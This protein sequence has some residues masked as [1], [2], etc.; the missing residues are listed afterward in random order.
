M[1]NGKA[2]TDARGA[3]LFACPDSLDGAFNIALMDAMGRMFVSRDPVG[4]RPM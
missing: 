3:F 4:F 2:F 1:R